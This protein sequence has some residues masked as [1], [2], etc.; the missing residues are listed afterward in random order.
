MSS[1]PDLIKAAVAII[2]IN[3]NLKFVLFIIIARDFF[4]C[5]PTT[6]CYDDYTSCRTAGSREARGCGRVRPGKQTL[7]SA[8]DEY[9]DEFDLLRIIICVLLSAKS[10]Y[11]ITNFLRV[12]CSMV[13]LPIA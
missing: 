10:V 12:T 4:C 5:R 1:N 6:L 9:N 7:F 8:A 3:P 2:Q 11:T 13:I